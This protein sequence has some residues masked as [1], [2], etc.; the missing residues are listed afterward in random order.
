MDG[1][2]GGYRVLWK[3]QEGK[4]SSTKHITSKV[5]LIERTSKKEG[6]GRQVKEAERILQV[7]GRIRNEDPEI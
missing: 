5:R 7:E 3:R 2:D 1:L 4:Q 6:R